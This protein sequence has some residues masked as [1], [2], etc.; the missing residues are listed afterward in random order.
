MRDEAFIYNKVKVD[1]E[2]IK[3]NFFKIIESYKSLCKIKNIV[4]SPKTIA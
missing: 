1:L 3:I 4:F 2:Y